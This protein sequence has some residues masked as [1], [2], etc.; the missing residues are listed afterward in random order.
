MIKNYILTKLTTIALLYSLPANSQVLI[1]HTPQWFGP[2]ANPVPE[3]TAA[4]IPAETKIS[5]AAESSFGFGDETQTLHFSAEI[6]LIP[7][8]V[9]LKFWSAAFEHYN[10]SDE[11]AAQRQMLGKNSGTATGDMYVQTRIRL[12]E[13]TH[14]RPS[15]V[16]NSTL[17]TSSG[18]GFINRRNFNTAGY[19]F[20]VEF[21]KSFPV[22]ASF[23]NELRLGTDF[24]FFCWDVQTPGNNVQDDAIMYGAKIL[25]K[26]DSFAW[27]NTLGGYYGWLRHIPDYGNKPLVYSTKIAYKRQVTQYFLQYTRGIQ[28]FPFHQMMAG[29]SFSLKN[30]TPDFAN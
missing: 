16:F 30:L 20:D 18:T 5:L 4:V 10:V 3:F 9:S 6:P 24:G 7:E 25:L 1:H 23:L 13:E 8:K 21:G 2:N 12:L 14:R 28:H 11:V 19:Y 22:E 26:N 29:A 17:K 27:E 15:V